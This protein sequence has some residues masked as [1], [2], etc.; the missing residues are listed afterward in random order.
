MRA[1]DII[2][3]RT[4]PLSLLLPSAYVQRSSSALQAYANTG[5]V[6]RLGRA[7]T[8]VHEFTGDLSY[9]TYLGSN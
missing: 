5:T 4:D 8:T 6:E 2:D 1:S 9:L 3:P 7:D